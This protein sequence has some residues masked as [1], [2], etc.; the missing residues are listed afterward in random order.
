[1]LR[2]LCVKQGKSIDEA[3]RLLGVPYNCLNQQLKKQLLPSEYALIPRK[4]VRYSD[5]EKRQI[6]NIAM[7]WKKSYKTMGDSFK[8]VS[9]E[10]GI[11][12][13]QLRNWRRALFGL[14]PP[15]G[16]NFSTEGD[17]LDGS[18]DSR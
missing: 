11:H 3:A 15:G 16:Y 6:M 5:E 9:K 14:V 12:V 7:D 8:A 4:R 17:L 18:D 10:Y 13:A 1:M 2:E